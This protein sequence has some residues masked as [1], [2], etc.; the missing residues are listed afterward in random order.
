[1]YL[2]EVILNFKGELYFSDQVFVCL[3]DLI[4]YVQS[5]IFL[6]KQGRVLMGWTSTKLG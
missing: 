2:T 6:I 5:T 4:L 1:M 3:F